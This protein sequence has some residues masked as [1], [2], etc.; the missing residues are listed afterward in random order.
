MRTVWAAVIVAATSASCA[1]H[2]PYAL[3]SSDQQRF[4]DRVLRTP[5][6]KNGAPL[7]FGLDD[8]TLYKA[9]TEHEDVTGWRIIV[10]RSD[11]GASYPKFLTMCTGQSLKYAGDYRGRDGEHH[12]QFTG[13]TGNW[14]PL[15]S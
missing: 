5:P 8:C 6:Q 2:V 12:W 14:D 11:W 7:I 4:G 10:L 3:S 15:P 1:P 13:M 9:Q